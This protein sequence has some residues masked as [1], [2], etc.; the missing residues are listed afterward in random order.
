M[1]G[2]LAISNL[3]EKRLMPG[4]FFDSN[5]ILYLT[6]ADSRKADRA[7]ELM[8]EGG[9]INVLVLNEIASVA[10]RKMAMSWRETGHFLSTI[11]DLLR[12]ESVTIETHEG[13]LA[14]AERYRLSVYDGMIAAAAIL[15]ECY[16]L[17]SEDLQN[18][19]RIGRRLRVANPFG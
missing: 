8:L 14:I 16:T 7:E 19:L 10:R 12:V 1:G 6:S 13:G 5:V 2:C 4:N 9:T 11:R 15:A 3:I 18:G 17:F